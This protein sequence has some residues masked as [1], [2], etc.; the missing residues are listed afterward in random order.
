[1]PYTYNLSKKDLY[2]KRFIH[3]SSLCF[4]FRFLFSI[5]SFAFYNHYKNESDK[6]IQIVPQ[7]TAMWYNGITWRRLSTKSISYMITKM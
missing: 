5:M 2:K 3:M 7:T 6:K 1:M 4:R